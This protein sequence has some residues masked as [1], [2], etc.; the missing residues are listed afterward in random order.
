MAAIQP[1]NSPRRHDI[2]DLIT[3]FYVLSGTNGDTFVCP[4]QDILNVI[5][6]PTTAISVG[7]TWSGSTVTFIS[8]GAW[9]ARVQIISRVG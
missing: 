2:G 9:A 6:T 4:Q 7:A 1:T 8:G 3:R 5:I